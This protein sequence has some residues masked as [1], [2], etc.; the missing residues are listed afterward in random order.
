MF[1]A[2]PEVFT[3]LKLNCTVFVHKSTIID[4]WLE[5]V[6]WHCRSIDDSCTLT[7]FS[8]LHLSTRY[9]TLCHVH[10]G[11]NKT[12][13]VTVLYW[14]PQVKICKKSAIK[15]ERANP[16]VK[17]VPICA[18]CING[19]YCFWGKKAWPPRTTASMDM[20]RCR[21]NP[22]KRWMPCHSA[23]TH[24]L[25]LSFAWPWIKLWRELNSGGKKNNCG[26][27]L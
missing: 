3:L 16:N 15:Y 11:T 4:F 20:I 18:K 21:V 2:V 14:A 19:V 7:R 27:L 22:S 17:N 10:S 24:V 6:W 1:N 5:D 25:L 8:Y 12:A 26:L 23:T 13:I 9:V